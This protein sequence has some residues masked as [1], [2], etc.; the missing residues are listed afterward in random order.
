MEGSSSV[1]LSALFPEINTTTVKIGLVLVSVVSI[2]KYLQNNETWNELT[3]R[4]LP[5][6]NPF[7]LWVDWDI[8]GMII[9][10]MMQ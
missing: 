6:L 9:M 1:P 10:Q 4:N 8:R 3:S 5:L 2:Q 7:F